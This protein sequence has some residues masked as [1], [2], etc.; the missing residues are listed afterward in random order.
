MR[1]NYLLIVVVVLLGCILFTVSSLD[2]ENPK[3]QIIKGFI[4]KCFTTDEPIGPYICL[5]A[6]PSY[7]YI[8]DITH[9][10]I[11]IFSKNG[12]KVKTFGRRGEGPK[13]FTSIDNM[14]YSENMLYVSSVKKLRIF[15]S[16]GEFVKEIRPGARQGA[17]RAYWPA[18]QD[19]IVYSFRNTPNPNDTSYYYVYRLVDPKL[20]RK[21]DF[22]QMEFEGYRKKSNR[23]EAPWSVYLDC[24]KAIVS[25]D[26]FYIGNTKWGF[27]IA[28]FDLS[29]KKL[30]EI[31]KNNPPVKVTSQMKD[32]MIS[33]FKGTVG[34]ELYNNFIKKRGF[35]FSETIP[36]YLNFFVENDKIYVFE[37]P[38]FSNNFMA[39]ILLLDSKGNLLKKITKQLIIYSIIQDDRVV[40]FNEG[41]LYFLS[42]QDDSISVAFIDLAQAFKDAK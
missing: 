8:G 36:S 1:I 7:I 16:N 31:K 28:V 18:G 3:L 39:N 4:K 29:G 19:Y 34:D 6:S 27:Y 9:C 23:D 40:S 41:K 38:D 33:Q 37:Y 26:R 22:F 12:Q 42:L 10:E 32:A 35:K 14:F 11:N 15:K 21:Y 30:Y 13:E 17:Y 5:T 24:Q 25:K 20:E 2:A